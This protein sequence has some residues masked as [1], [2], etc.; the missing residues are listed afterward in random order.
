MTHFPLAPQDSLLPA[1]HFIPLHTSLLVPQ[2]WYLLML[3]AFTNLIYLL[4]YL[5]S[6]KLP[7]LSSN[8]GSKT[9]S[10]LLDNDGQLRDR[11]KI[12]HRVS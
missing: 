4:T 2:I 6:Y 9:G 7:G 11:E 10:L 5:L 8:K 1:S 3:C 12:K